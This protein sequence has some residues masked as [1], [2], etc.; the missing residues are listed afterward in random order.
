MTSGACRDELHPV[1]DV[2]GLRSGLDVRFVAQFRGDL[3]IRRPPRQIH[4]LIAI[5][6]KVVQHIFDCGVRSPPRSCTHSFRSKLCCAFGFGIASLKVAAVVAEEHED[7]VQGR[8]GG[9]PHQ[10]S[11]R[12]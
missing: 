1:E 10:D 4:I 3:R 11:S 6:R 8:Q 12:S 5:G 7:R 2:E 9:L